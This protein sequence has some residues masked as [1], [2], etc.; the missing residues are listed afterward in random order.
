MPLGCAPSRILPF[1][2]NILLAISQIHKIARR[3]S[4]IGVR[5]HGNDA[6]RRRFDQH[7]EAV[8]GCFG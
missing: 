3:V 7:T 8:G 6:V 1:V 4:V 2:A 5:R